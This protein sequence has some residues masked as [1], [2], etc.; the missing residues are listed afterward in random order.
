M[1][2]GGLQHT[3]TDHVRMDWLF[4]KLSTLW[5]RNRWWDRRQESP[6]H[7]ERSSTPSND[8]I[9]AD[10]VPH[11]APV[12]TTHRDHSTTT[13]PSAIVAESNS[14]D[15]TIYR[16]SSGR[17]YALL[18]GNC[19][20][21]ASGGSLLQFVHTDLKLL[22]DA[23]G[24]CNAKVYN[25]CL[26]KGSPFVTRSEL[27]EY[28]EKAKEY[29]VE[30]KISYFM[31][32]FTG[33]GDN[34]GIILS[35]DR[36]DK[37]EYEEIIYSISSL[38]VP[39]VLIFDC[40]RLKTDK[41]TSLTDATLPADC[42]VVFACMDDSE[43]WGCPKTGSYFTHKLANALKAYYQRGLSLP[44]IIT[45]AVHGTRELCN[46]LNM[47]VLDIQ[48]PMILTTI[49][50]QFCAMKGKSFVLIEY[51]HQFLPLILS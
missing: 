9:E 11:T 6:R 18:T 46:A 16:Y 48:N 21:G 26:D 44:D 27:F 10:R 22:Q 43:A 17:T 24:C 45:Q 33:H 32:Y 20:G 19:G 7:S 5:P 36:R 51:G 37:A 23:L 35:G 14:N 30:N 49:E 12:Q 47:G 40:C 28:L 15:Q 42:H 31:F 29:V 1:V 25:P 38:D 2:W 3:Y 34:T 8:D 4:S 41:K 39:K 50:G 13:D